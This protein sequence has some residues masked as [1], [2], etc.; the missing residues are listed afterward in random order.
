M[1]NS[2]DLAWGSEVIKAR[3]FHEDGSPTDLK[4]LLPPPAPMIEVESVS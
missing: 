4:I 2:I 3:T 1:T